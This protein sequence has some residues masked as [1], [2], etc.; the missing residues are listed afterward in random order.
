MP[1]LQ[2]KTALIT[3]ATGGIGEATARRFLS[4]GANVMLLGRSADKLDATRAALGD[5]TQIAQFVADPVDETA[6][7]NAVAATVEAFGGLDILFANAGSLGVA[8]PFEEQTLQEFEDVIRPNVTGVWLSM[9]HA[10]G[11]MKQRGAGSIIATS[12][13][14]GAVG[15]AHL[16]PYSA[17]K[18]AVCGLV[19]TAALELATSGIRVNAVLPGPIDNK[20]TRSFAAKAA[21]DDPDSAV[22][23]VADLAPAKRLGT[24]EEVANLVL[25]LASDD[26]IYCTGGLYPVDGGWTAA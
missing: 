12:S 18:H 13:T 14:F 17:S 24:N 1:R 5:T 8:K 11:P 4:E 22:A 16:A 25:F 6:T 9:K 7:A 15:F 26:S 3:G 23:A 20:L 19:K 21:P 10:V 2:G